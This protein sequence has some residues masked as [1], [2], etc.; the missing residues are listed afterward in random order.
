MLRKDY[1]IGS[2]TEAEILACFSI[3]DVDVLA[4]A[5]L[6]DQSRVFEGI[7][8]IWYS[9]NTPGMNFPGPADHI[10]GHNVDQVVQLVLR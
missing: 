2:V 10:N 5:E 6:F 7:L 9:A 4:G 8:R 3:E 1:Y